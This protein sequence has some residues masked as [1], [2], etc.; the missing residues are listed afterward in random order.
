MASGSTITSLPVI[1]KTS[2]PRLE[3]FRSRIIRDA[4]DVI[5]LTP[6]R[7]GKFSVNYDSLPLLNGKAGAGDYTDD[8]DS[9]E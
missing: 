5:L 1:Y 6:V 7:M 4:D 3:C 2:I 9:Y 8:G